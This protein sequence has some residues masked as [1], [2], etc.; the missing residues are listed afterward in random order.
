[1]AR[2]PEGKRRSSRSRS[3]GKSSPVRIAFVID[4][5]VL[6]TAVL[7][8]AITLFLRPDARDWA[9]KS[10][11]YGW[12]PVGLW[13]GALIFGLRYHT[14][15]IAR[16]WQWWVTAAAGVGIIIGVL[17]F[18]HPGFGVFADVS[19]GG[20]WGTILGGA[21]LSLGIAKLLIIAVLTPVV[22]FPKRVGPLYARAF[23]QVGQSARFVA[24]HPLLKRF[25]GAIAQKLKSRTEDAAGDSSAP[26]AITELTPE[27]SAVDPTVAAVAA[28][29]DGKP[30]QDDSPAQPEVIP[31][32]PAD[33]RSEL[34]AI[35]GFVIDELSLYAEPVDPDPVSNPPWL[36]PAADLL[37]DPEPVESNEE[38][39][40]ATARLIEDTLASYGAN[41]TVPDASIQS[42]PRLNRFGLDPGW[43]TD[44][45]GGSDDQQDGDGGGRSRV[46]VQAILARQND[47]ALALKTPTIRIQP[48]IPGE[49]LVGLEVPSLTPR[50][51]GLKEV[52]ESQA[53]VDCAAKGGLPVAIGLDIAGEPEVLDLAGLPHLL[54]AGATGTGKSVCLN[55]I[56]ASLL[57]SKSPDEMRLLMV[58][59]KGVELTPFDGLPHLAAPTVQEFK[60]FTESLKGLL[61]LMQQ[62]Y[63]RLAEAGARNIAGYNA[64]AERRMP[65]VVLVV[66]EL[67]E[68]MLA[69]GREA[70]ANLVRLAQMGRAT[71]IHLMLATQRPT[72]D[73][74]TGLLKA[75]IATRIAFTV[76]S[77]T[78]S[79]V[80][81]DVSGAEDLLGRG[82]MLLLENQSPQP[83]RVQG[84]F[85]D[86]GEVSRLVEFWRD[87]SQS[88]PP[89]LEVELDEEEIDG[90]EI[91]DEE[92]DDADTDDLE[93][94]DDDAGDEETTDSESE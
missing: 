81:L 62:R 63:T 48:T 52:V 47:L 30:A 25:R 79:R 29:A 65:Y 83:R 87:P 64:T 18:F 80:I 20:R 35:D 44:D 92:I 82:D 27:P 93:S 85:V 69:G 31:G 28:V 10:L 12:A 22:V 1:M 4:G 59:P 61:S 73:V 45:K 43:L 23:E 14:K 2:T 16:Q 86:D 32:T 24:E 94:E 70:E 67:A 78:D 84:T 39:L 13:L 89:A 7:A 57:V 68:L 74:V 58:D 3:G 55:S 91:V 66:D 41:V 75:N 90:E 42:G 50:R 60:G 71:G 76:A 26:E 15:S 77:Q 51:V 19:L 11:A 21:P 5:L 38:A 72:V 9:I 40:A 88:R 33:T 6:V 49:S 36:L 54:I 8:L 34:S 46:R 37:T 53:F 17:S 56:V